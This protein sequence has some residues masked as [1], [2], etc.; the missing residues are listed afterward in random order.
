MKDQTKIA[1]A[2]Y[3][4]DISGLKLNFILQNSILWMRYISMKRKILPT[5][6]M[7]WKFTFKREPS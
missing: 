7:E 1:D 5:Y 3:V 2:T 6:Q 4:D